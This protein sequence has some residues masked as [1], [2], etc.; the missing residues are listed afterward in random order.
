VASKYAKVGG[1][2]VN[3]DQQSGSREGA[4]DRALDV[5][6]TVVLTGTRSSLAEVAEGAA[7]PKPTAHRILQ[8]LVAR[9]YARQAGD[10]TYGPGLKIL[11]LAGQLDETLELADLARPAMLELQ[12][13]LPETVHLALLQGDHATY[14]AK[15]EGRRAYRMASVIGSTLALHSTSIGKAVLAFLPEQQRSE[16][17]GPEPWPRRTEH[18]ITTSSALARDLED[19]RARAFSL[20][21]EENEE[22]IRCVGAAVFDRHGQVIGGV[23]LSAP[24]FA[25]TFEDALVVGPSVARAA[26]AISC[27]LGARPERLPAVYQSLI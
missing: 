18:T 12:A 7:V 15:L 17:I 8:T 22:Q 16:A 21:N 19:I 24:A 11:T 23:S 13:T 27:S 14:V 9:G 20:D 10:G 3:G 6:E 26:A 25:L 2:V 5:L 1:N 4:V